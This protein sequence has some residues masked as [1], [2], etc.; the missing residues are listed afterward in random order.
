[1]D[2]GFSIAEEKCRKHAIP[3]AKVF[4]KPH[5][6]NIDAKLDIIKLATP[7]SMVVEARPWHPVNEANRILST[8]GT[9][10]CRAVTLP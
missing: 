7:G 10:S 4:Y 2:I 9:V 6:F 8:A 5:E 3:P 1:M